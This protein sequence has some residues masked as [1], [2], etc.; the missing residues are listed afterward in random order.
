MIPIQLS[1]AIEAEAQGVKLSELRR[2]SAAITERYS[3]QKSDGARLVATKEEALVYSIVRMPATY[4]AV[5]C[6]L[7]HTL[8]L[9]GELSICSALDIGAGTGA[10][11]WAT[12]Q[13]VSVGRIDCLEREREMSALG[14]RLAL[15]LQT[16]LRW[17]ESDVLS[18]PLKEEYDF[19]V[20]SYALNE[21]SPPQREAVLSKLWAHTRKL[22]LIV[23][24]GT[25]YAFSLQREM[26]QT[27]LRQGGN[28]VAPCPQGAACAIGEDDWCHFTCRV[29]RSK[30]HRYVKG[31]DAPFE[32]EKF[33]YSAFLK[34]APVRVC[35]ER[36]LRHPIT[37][38]KK[39]DLVCC[40]KEGIVGRSLRK[41]DEGYKRAK[42]LGAG[43]A[44]LTA[45]KGD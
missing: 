22:L 17:I 30:L 1:A 34:G 37:E 6:A 3:R 43:D 28:L 36:I 23:E 40:T 18:Y 7:R 15:P 20:A 33:T 19:V 12:A 21:M 44:F 26:R 39:V 25:P 8:E 10:A 27:L 38:V 29:A 2:V 5:L 42:K 16:P 11:A 45:P 4:S 32:D 31:G 14:K 13:C 41:K 9:T 35:V 24:P